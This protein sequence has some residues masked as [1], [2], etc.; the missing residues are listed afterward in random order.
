MDDLLPQGTSDEKA[1]SR[2]KRPA[3]AW[4]RRY[5]G[6]A[7]QEFFGH[8]GA[9]NFGNQVLLFGAGLLL[10]V[11][12][13]VILLSAFAA[14]RIDVDIAR[15]MSLDRQGAQDMSRLFTSVRCPT[16]PGQGIQ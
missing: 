1:E 13:I 15:H 11:L 2:L 12:P 3:K 6:S 16:V 10:S 7:A 5:E 8:L 4:R 9:L 14:H